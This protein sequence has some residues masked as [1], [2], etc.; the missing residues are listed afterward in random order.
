VQIVKTDA[1]HGSTQKSPQHCGGYCYF[2]SHWNSL[3]VKVHYNTC[4]HHDRPNVDK[5]QVS[6]QVES[7]VEYDGWQETHEEECRT[8]VLELRVSGHTFSNE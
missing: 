5:E 4:K 6:L 8:E 7:A 3:L 2:Y 1:N